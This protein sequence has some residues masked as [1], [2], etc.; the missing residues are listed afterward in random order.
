VHYDTHDVIVLQVLGEKR[1]RLWPGQ[2][3]PQPTRRTPW[4]GGIEPEGEPVAVTMRPGDTLY[5]PRGVMHDAAAQDGSEPSLHVTVGLLEPSFATVLRLALDLLEEGDPA[6][7]RAFPTW[8]LAEGPGALAAIAQP[9]AA[10]LAEPAALERTALALLDRLAEDR[11][12]AA[13]ARLFLRPRRRRTPAA[14]RARRAACAGAGGGGR[15]LAPLGGRAHHAVRHRGGVGGAA[16]GRRD[17]SPTGEVRRP[18]AC[19]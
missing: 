1:W 6:L 13:R 10:K 3:V 4:P 9:L 11:P 7:R 14:A 15:R 18:S 12:G 16:G 8:R 2:P 17:P 5:V 19:G